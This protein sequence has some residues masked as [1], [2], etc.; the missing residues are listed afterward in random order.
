M[1]CGTTVLNTSRVRRFRIIY[2]SGQTKVERGT[3]VLYGK[4][5]S[6][7]TVLQLRYH[8]SERDAE[9]VR[10]VPLFW[11]M[12]P[13][14]TTVLEITLTKTRQCTLSFFLYSSYSYCLFTF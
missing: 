9:K 5:L 2:H 13:A 12:F 7:T 10:E 8:R 6:G 4:K 3:T 11:K 14:G 1:R